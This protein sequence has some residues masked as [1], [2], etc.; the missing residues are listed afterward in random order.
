MK[1]TYRA[2]PP[3]KLPIV[4][5]WPLAGLSSGGHMIAMYIREE[6]ENRGV[7]RREVKVESCMLTSSW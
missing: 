7:G 5:T 1:H 3:T 6:K 2:A 4:M